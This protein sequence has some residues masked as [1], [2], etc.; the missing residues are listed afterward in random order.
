M[1]AGQTNPDRAAQL[2]QQVTDLT[3]HIQ[4][5][6]TTVEQ[7]QTTLANVSAFLMDVVA[8]NPHLMQRPSYKAAA[9][10]LSSF[11]SS[12]PSTQSPTPTPSNTPSNVGTHCIIKEYAIYVDV[13][14]GNTTHGKPNPLAG[15]LR[16]PG[17][18]NALVDTLNSYLTQLEAD[19]GKYYK[20]FQVADFR[21]VDLVDDKRQNN[22]RWKIRCDAP[23]IVERI[24]YLRFDFGRNTGCWFNEVLTPQQERNRNSMEPT[25]K[26]ILGFKDQHPISVWFR[27]GELYACMDK[28]QKGR[29]RVNHQVKS[30]DAA[31]ALLRE[32]GYLTDEPPPRR[33]PAPTPPPP[34]PPPP[35]HTHVPVPATVHPASG[36]TVTG[37]QAPPP[38]PADSGGST[39]TATA[40]PNSPNVHTTA[41][42]E[43]VPTAMDPD[44]L[45]GGKRV[46]TASMEKSGPDPQRQRQ[47]QESPT[48]SK[49]AMSSNK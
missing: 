25:K 20:R 37:A 16:D 7:L 9:A 32:A 21:H 24:L 22:N 44:P 48:R 6:G 38:P 15:N 23:T 39:A 36:T 5:M 11:N 3:N 26:F 46:A 10:S 43:T 30:M 2:E 1:E 28:T 49:P 42:S 47:S 17:G 34:P 35:S 40:V 13:P 14:I 12:Y 18:M 33:A 19:S 41:Q 29:N 31:K 4:H 45:A 27:E 8:A